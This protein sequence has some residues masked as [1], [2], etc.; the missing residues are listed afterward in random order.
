MTQV[1]LYEQPQMQQ[2]QQQQ[3]PPPYTALPYASAPIDQGYGGQQTFA[4]MPQQQQQL[5]YV[6]GAAP[7]YGPPPTMYN[8]P[9]QPQYRQQ[10]Y[11]G[12]PQTRVAVPPGMTRESLQPGYVPGLAPD[13]QRRM[14]NPQWS[15][16]DSF[17][18]SRSKCCTI[19]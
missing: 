12:L 8:N 1:P 10:Q 6:G 3:P 4:S 13:Q 18:N 9:T 11:M 17:G 5:Q 16:R 15:F 19:S 2:Q 7:G 14:F